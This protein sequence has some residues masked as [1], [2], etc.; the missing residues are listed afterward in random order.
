MTRLDISSGARWS[1]ESRCSGCQYVSSR[2]S[3]RPMRIVAYV[4]CHTR[5]SIM[6]H[7]F[8]QHL[9]R[10]AVSRGGRPVRWE[11]RESHNT[12]IISYLG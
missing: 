1:N 12:S 10:L 11:P 3:R 6:I 7:G 5:S 8:L 4:P 9:C 2:D